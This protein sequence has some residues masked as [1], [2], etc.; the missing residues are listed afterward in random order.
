[1]I[2]HTRLSCS[3]IGCADTPH[4]F[5]IKDLWIQSIENTTASTVRYKVSASDTEPAIMRSVSISADGSEIAP[6]AQLKWKPKEP[7]MRSAICS[8]RSITAISFRLTNVSRKI[9]PRQAN[10]PLE[11]DDQIAI[12]K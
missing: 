8:T 2:N 10:T 4:I 11:S 9:F 1:M 3:A 7:W 5:D 6:M 12:I